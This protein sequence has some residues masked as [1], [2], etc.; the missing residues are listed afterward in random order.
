[1][2]TGL[3]QQ[4]GTLS[5]RE[6][7]AGGLRLV[8][9]GTPWNPPLTLGE[10]MA[11]NGACLTLAHIQGKNFACDILQETL[12]R[13]TLGD[14]R[15]G[16]ALNL[17]RALRLGDPLGGHMV[18]G[19]VDGIGTVNRR[20]A[21]G[22]DWILRVTCGTDLLRGM[23]LK[24][25]I[26][27]DGV[28]LTIAE[29]DGYSFVVALIPFTCAHTTL[30]ALKAGD[31]VNLETDLIGKHVRRTMETEQVPTPLTLDRLHK[32]GFGEAE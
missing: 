12:D 26:A 10:S 3:I 4:I 5:R 22:R 17:E 15:P 13:T 23:V 8:I 16:A 30:G 7:V 18:T 1:M 21:N 14:K 28:S 29:L 9:A 19:H 11:V 31:T 32:A 27:I 24:G 6:T 20:Q 25:S 2:F